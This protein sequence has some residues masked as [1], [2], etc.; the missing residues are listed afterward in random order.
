MGKMHLRPNLTS[1]T[2][3]MA[4]FQRCLWDAQAV[5]ERKQPAGGAHGWIQI[6]NM[7]R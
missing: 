2:M 3:D 6:E 1:K 4:A 7:E 5:Q